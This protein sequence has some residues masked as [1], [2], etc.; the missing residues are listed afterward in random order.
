M[1][2]QREVKELAAM[3]L[4]GVAPFMRTSLPSANLGW[5][6]RGAGVCGLH[7]EEEA[8]EA[9]AACCTLEAAEEA[10][11]E[12]TPGAPAEPGTTTTPALCSAV[13]VDAAGCPAALA[14]ISWHHFKAWRTMK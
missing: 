14:Q 11:P 6:M 13:A 4:W 8:E 7:W 12:C 1:H 10:P 3:G 2:P 9:V 5:G